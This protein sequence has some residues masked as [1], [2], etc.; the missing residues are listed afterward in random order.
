MQRH[1]LLL[2]SRRDI[3]AAS[4]QEGGQKLVQMLANF[5]RQGF[6]LLATA[7]L[8]LEWSK[9]L[10]VSRRS[11]PAPKGVRQIIAEAGGSLDGVYYV[12][13]SLLTQKTN[14]E[15]ALKD[16]LSRFGT[17]PTECYLFSSSRKF[18]AAAR[19][20]NIKAFDIENKNTLECLLTEQLD[21]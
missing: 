21:I 11:V 15:T 14:R 5:T 18:V 20:L 16:I 12:P 13:R 2:I 17:A 1:P 6:Q 10:A 3:L 4:Q 9:S 7:S 8:P 19:R